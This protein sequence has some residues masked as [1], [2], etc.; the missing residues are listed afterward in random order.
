MEIKK[1]ERDMASHMELNP[2]PTGVL[3]SL[4]LLLPIVFVAAFFWRH[5]EW[6]EMTMKHTVKAAR[7]QGDKDAAAVWIPK[8]KLSPCKENA[9]FAKTK[10]RKR[11]SHKSEREGVRK[12]ERGSE[13]EQAG[14]LLIGAKQTQT[15]WQWECS[16]VPLPF[17]SHFVDV[18]SVW[19]CSSFF[20]PHCCCC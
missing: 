16:N 3:F 19:S 8:E 13:R 15:K 11:Q 1:R 10:W 18:V 20:S 4:F 17:R 6:G 5:H 14:E 7:R 12:R 2:I 9:V